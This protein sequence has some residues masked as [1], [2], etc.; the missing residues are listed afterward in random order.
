MWAN[1]GGGL[2]NLTDPRN[3][4]IS[5]TTATHD[6]LKGPMKAAAN[7]ENGVHQLLILWFTKFCVREGLGV[8]ND[9]PPKCANSRPTTLLANHHG[10][11]DALQIENRSLSLPV[12]D[13]AFLDLNDLDRCFRVKLIV[14]PPRGLSA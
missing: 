2:W 13:S 1:E 7:R 5:S 9:A 10:V 3:V 12:P 8:L 14:R 6:K 4:D 11:D